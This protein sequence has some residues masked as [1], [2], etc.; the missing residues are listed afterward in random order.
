MAELTARGADGISGLPA[1]ARYSA[2]VNPTRREIA[3]WAFGLTD[4]E[5]REHPDT[6]ASGVMTHYAQPIIDAHNW[7][8]PGAPHD[9]RF[10]FTL[11]A[12]DQGGQR[13]L[14]E[15][16]RGP[17]TVTVIDTDPNLAGWWW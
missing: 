13:G 17:G 4:D 14:I 12:F 3:L 11:W 7:T 1:H 8:N 15:R 6:P 9:R 5:V 2:A 10:T 16:G